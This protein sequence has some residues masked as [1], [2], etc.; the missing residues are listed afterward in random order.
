MEALFK[1]IDLQEVVEVDEDPYL[2]AN[3]TVA[4]MK[5]LTKEMANEVQG[6]FLYSPACIQNNICEDCLLK[7]DK[8]AQAKSRKSS[9]E[10]RIEALFKED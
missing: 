7:M 9:K 3:P 2:R 8:E 5:P 4:K 10:V 1:G 6:P